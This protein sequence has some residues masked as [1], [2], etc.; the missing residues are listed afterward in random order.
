MKNI[1]PIIEAHSAIPIDQLRVLGRFED[2]R[3]A[4]MRRGIIF[5]LA[6]WS[7]P[8]MK[9]LQRFTRVVNTLKA[10]VLDLVILDID[11]LT[12]DSATQ[13]FGTEG[14]RAGGNGETIW[15]RDGLIVARELAAPDNA[16][17]LLLKHTKELL[18]APAGC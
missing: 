9:A 8:A 10:D 5:V 12:K 2:V 6:V 11:C 14:F 16:A 15:V 18:N 1:R 17:P 7:A 3:I 4:E 13:L